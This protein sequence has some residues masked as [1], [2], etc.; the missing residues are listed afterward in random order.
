[1]ICLTYQGRDSAARLTAGRLRQVAIADG[2]RQQLTANSYR[3]WPIAA[4]PR[5]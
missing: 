4:Q 5:R 3:R 2:W 1:M